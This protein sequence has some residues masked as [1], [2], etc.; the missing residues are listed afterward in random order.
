MIR[1]MQKGF[2]LQELEQTAGLI[3]AYDLPTVWFFTFGGPGESEDTVKETFGFIDRC[4]PPHDLVRLTAGLRIY[5]GTGLHARAIDERL[6]THGDSLLRP[7]YY[8]EPRLGA[9]RLRALLL[10]EAKSRPN[11]LTDD[12]AL[13][14][15]E[16]LDSARRLRKEQNLTEPMFRTLVRLRTQGTDARDGA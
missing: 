9:E 11:C 10:D 2:T 12:Q 7:A 5:P 16:L 1:S 15:R 4:L 14:S 13:P 6:I 3:R 8:V